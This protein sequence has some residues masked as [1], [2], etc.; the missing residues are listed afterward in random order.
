MPVL[1]Q[2]ED[3]KRYYTNRK[4]FFTVRAMRKDGSKPKAPTDGEVFQ[5]FVFDGQDYPQERVEQAVRAVSG[6]LAAPSC[7]A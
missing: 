3:T 2:S 1:E 7:A 6:N 4:F 5:G